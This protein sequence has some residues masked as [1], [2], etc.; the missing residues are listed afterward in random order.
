MVSPIAG[1]RGALGQNPAALVL[2]ALLDPFGPVEPDE[3]AGKPDE[4][5]RAKEDEGGAPAKG[6]G[7]MS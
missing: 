1:S 7:D 3:I 6:A 5:E 2:G 4:T